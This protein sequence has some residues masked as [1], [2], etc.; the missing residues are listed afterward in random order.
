MPLRPPPCRQAAGAWGLEVLRYEIRDI[1]PP[2]SVRHAMDLQAE[3]E[4]RKRAQ[5][6]GEAP[7]LSC[8]VWLSGDLSLDFSLLRPGPEECVCLLGFLSTSWSL[9]GGWRARI[10]HWASVVH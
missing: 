8:G 6:R 5:V 9:E 7:A 1:T 10:Q 3:A 2:S 4:R